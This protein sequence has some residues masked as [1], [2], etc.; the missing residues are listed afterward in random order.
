[1]TGIYVS[2]QGCFF[3]VIGV[4]LVTLY[5]FEGLAE[6]PASAAIG[7]MAALYRGILAPILP[8]AA[9]GTCTLGLKELQYA[10]D[11][12]CYCISRSSSVVPCSAYIWMNELIPP[13]IL[14][15]LTPWQAICTCLH[16]G[17]FC[18]VSVCF[19]I[20]IGRPLF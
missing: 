15:E 14:E 17:L 20:A 6:M 18:N 2:L 16:T 11:C 4:K 8:H 1:M 5:I 12:R 3:P 7:L 10:S 19:I 9:P 13:D